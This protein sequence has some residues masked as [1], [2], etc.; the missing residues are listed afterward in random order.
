MI[1]IHELQQR[2]L[3]LPNEAY[4]QDKKV[5]ETKEALEMEKINYDVNYSMALLKAQKSNATEKKCEA[6]VV[7][8]EEKIKLLK[9]SINFEKANAILTAK[10]NEF[11]ALRKVSSIEEALMKIGASGN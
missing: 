4:Q 9:A 7:T 2:L 6:M 3:A 10:N 11:I 5:I 8:K 1:N